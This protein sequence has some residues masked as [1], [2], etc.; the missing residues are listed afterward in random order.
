M[1]AYEVVK[2]NV[3]E[4][5][6]PFEVWVLFG[7]Q[8]KKIEFLGDYICLGEDSA[9]LERCRTAIAW[10]VDQLGGKVKWNAD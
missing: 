6:V 2:H 3:V 7:H 5:E 4:I 8:Q 10:Y 1:K 9:S